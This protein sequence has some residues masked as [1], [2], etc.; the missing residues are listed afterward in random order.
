MRTPC[1][2][3]LLLSARTSVPSVDAARPWILAAT[4]L[5]SSM[6]FIDSTVVNVVLPTSRFVLAGRAVGAVSRRRLR[7]ATSDGNDRRVQGGK[8]VFDSRTGAD[9]NLD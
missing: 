2:A 7:R 5:G 9:M 3:V 4:I 6:A 8:L 1:D